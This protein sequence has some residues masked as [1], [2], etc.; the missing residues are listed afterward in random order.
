[1]NGSRAIRNAKTMAVDLLGGAYPRFVYGG[2]VRGV[3]VFAS[4]GVTPALFEAQLA[5]VR[6]NGYRTLSA[7]EFY[8]IAC[9]RR[10]PE[11][12]AVM[13]TYDDGLGSLWSVGLP[14]VK[15]YGVTIVVFLIPGRIRSGGVGPTLEDLAAGRARIEDV[16][17]RDA[18]EQPF[19]TWDEITQ[20]HES[21][22]VD[23]QSH[24]LTHQLMFTSPRIEG[25]FNPALARRL[26]PFQLPE[27]M[28]NG[29]SRPA[30]GRPLY[31][32]A[33]RMSAGRHYLE[34][35]GLRR[36]CEGYVAERGGAAFFERPAWRRELATSSRDFRRRHG[37]LGRFET[38]EERQAALSS[39]LR[40]AKRFIEE[41]LPGKTVRHLAY[42]WGA[43]SALAIRLSAQAGY[44][45]NF[46]AKV[47][48]SYMGITRGQP[49]I[50]GRFGMDF[51][52]RLPG[53]GRQPL[54][55]TLAKKLSRNVANLPEASPE[56]K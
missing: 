56:L 47:A 42:P 11:Q 17:Q 41:Q 36:A 1:M 21:G 30:W 27:W 23:F 24:T 53:R 6:D 26:S 29:L 22:L 35:A 20:M 10:A 46:P 51:L 50:A 54:W 5:F 39:E 16:L 3:P 13:L 52:F 9:G 32:A 49:L 45:T 25:Y 4:H 12:R 19:L 48:G 7:D 18:G 31:T 14:L 43:D 38:A 8:E 55:R 37:D 28:A 2:G 15:R 33:P 40:E 34:D 44:V